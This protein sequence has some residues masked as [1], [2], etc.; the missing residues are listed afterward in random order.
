MLRELLVGPLGSGGHRDIDERFAALQLTD[1]DEEGSKAERAKSVAAKLSASQLRQVAD[2]FL[3]NNE[4]APATRNAVQD[5]LWANL[6]PSVPE[7]VRRELAAALQIADIV[8]DQKRFEALLDRWWV[9]G[10]LGPFEDVFAG[11]ASTLAEM[12]GPSSTQHLLRKQIRRHVFDNPGDWSVEELLDELGAFDAIDSRFVRFLEDLVSHAN[13]LRVENQQQVVNTL[14]PLLRQA[15]G[16]EL[17]E[18]DT[19]GGY[20]VFRIVSPQAIHRPPKTVIFGSQLKPDL[21]VS[22]T[23]NNDLDIVDAK[24]ALVYD[25]P[26]GPTGLQFGD[27]A[28]WWQ[29][30]RP[31]PA[32]EE[33]RHSLYRRLFNA[34]PDKSPPQQRVFNLYHRLHSEHLDAMPALLPEVWLHWDP[35]TVQQRG[36]QALLGQRMDFLILG[37]NNQRIIIEV[38]GKTHYTDSHGRPSPQ[39]YAQNTRYDRTMQLRGYTIY[40]FGAIELDTDT[41]AEILL[42]QFFS[43]MFHQHNIASRP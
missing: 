42:A 38:D 30:T 15:D 9:L 11:D 14:A 36:P 39:V 34:I 1:L 10:D 37:P 23:V 17:R 33:A 3:A 20:P 16:L 26:I 8:V 4:L 35:K 27:L 21:R 6:G 5:V 43:D 18:V 7:R 31:D 28:A 12:F 19:D 41:D 24:G 13:L 2:H 29:R 25:Q 40:R 22:D 32:G